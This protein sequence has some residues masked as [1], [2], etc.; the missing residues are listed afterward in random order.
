MG[1]V[2]ETTQIIENLNIYN[3]NLFII[4][5]LNQN[6]HNFVQFERLPFFKTF[7]LLK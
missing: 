7:P 5:Q 1:Q 4:K 6:T 3:I 2:D